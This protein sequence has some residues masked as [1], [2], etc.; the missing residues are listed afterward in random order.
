M[1]RI[2]KKILHNKFLRDLIQSKLV[3]LNYKINAYIEGN[4]QIREINEEKNT[5]LISSENNSNLPRGFDDGIYLKLNPDVKEAG[6]DPALHF[7]KYGL[8]EGRPW[9]KNRLS[10]RPE[11]ATHENI[12]PWLEEN[13]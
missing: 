10:K 1:K 6:E 2:I 5:S 8:Q 11:F 13:A 3:D 9:Q 4:N 7:L 12:W